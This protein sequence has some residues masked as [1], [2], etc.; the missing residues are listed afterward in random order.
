MPRRIIILFAAVVLVSIIVVQLRHES[1]QR[2]S[3][4]Q[5]RQAERDALNVEWGKLLLEEGAWSQH[6]RI[7]MMA[8]QR[9][10]MD[11]PDASSIRVVR[12]KPDSAL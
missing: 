2:F 11:T 6:R 7:E 4:L 10:D 5:A 3:E 12:M 9:L 8:R 1:R